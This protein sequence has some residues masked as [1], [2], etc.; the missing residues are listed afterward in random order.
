MA[1]AQPSHATANMPRLAAAPNNNGP[2]TQPANCPLITKP[3]AAA[4]ALGFARTIAVDNRPVQPLPA[5]KAISVP[6]AYSPSN[7]DARRAIP[8]APATH[9]SPT[10]IRCARCSRSPGAPK[11]T[12]PATAPTLPAAS[13]HPAAD[14]DSP[15]WPADSA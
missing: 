8:I 2:M 15:T 1:A 6:T 7:D 5:V 9:N 10:P 13:H 14:G 11:P 12:R 4:G 3:V